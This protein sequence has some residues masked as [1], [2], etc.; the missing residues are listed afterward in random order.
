MIH[1]NPTYF[2]LRLKP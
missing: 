2:S 1:F